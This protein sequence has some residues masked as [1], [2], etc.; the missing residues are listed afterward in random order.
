MSRVINVSIPIEPPTTTFQAKKINTKTGKIYSSAAARDARQS[1]HAW[2]SKHVPDKP[3]SGPLSL[4]M[5]FKF[6]PPKSIAKRMGQILYDY[7]DTKPDCDNLTKLV[8]DVMQDLGYFNND[9]Q[10]AVLNVRKVWLSPRTIEK[11][12]DQ[13]GVD[14]E[15]FM[16]DYY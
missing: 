1:Y 9:S 11:R 8:M 2:L 12:I 3:M 14:I 16:L 10:V 5:T 7:K 13:P 4:T 6:S 15:L